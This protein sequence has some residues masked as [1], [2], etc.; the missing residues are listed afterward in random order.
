V[1]VPADVRAGSVDVHAIALLPQ[2]GARNG[3]VIFGNF[4]NSDSTR[5]VWAALVDAGYGFSHVLWD[6]YRR[7]TVVDV[8][9]DW[10]WCSGD[11]SPSWYTGEPDEE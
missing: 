4:K 10:G 3:M 11:P 5:E 2:F 8:L 9:N 7:E 6:K 1:I